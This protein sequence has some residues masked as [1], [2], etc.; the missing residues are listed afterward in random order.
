MKK[1]LFYLEPAIFR[2]DPLFLAPHISWLEAIGK[3]LSLTDEDAIAIVSSAPLCELG[4]SKLAEGGFPKIKTKVI[5]VG[6]ALEEFGGCRQAYAQDL[7]SS[8]SLPI[9]NQYLQTRIKSIIRNF[10]PDLVIATAENRYI[11]ALSRNSPRRVGTFFI[12]K[13]P[14]PSWTLK[15]RFYLDPEGHQPNSLLATRWAGI[16]AED[17]EEEDLAAAENFLAEIESFNNRTEN[18]TLQN[19]LKDHLGKNPRETILVSLQPDEWL[20]WEGAIQS[21][22]KPLDVLTNCCSAFPDYNILPTFHRNIVGL[23]DDLLKDMKSMFPN[24]IDLPTHMVTGNTERLIP[25]VDHVYSVSS[26][27]GIT[28]VINSK[29]LISD[30][31]S[32]LHGAAVTS[33]DFLAGKRSKLTYDQKIRLVAWLLQKYSMPFSDLRTYE[34]YESHGKKLM[35]SGHVGDVPAGPAKHLD[36]LP[37][38]ENWLRRFFKNP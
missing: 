27:T 28:A 31:R 35:A 18:I 36:T 24:L 8:P 17:Y 14:L 13:A 30:A 19:K 10:D 29:N 32:F 33:S 12:E 22:L 7:Y 38:R 3:N 1:L 34:D 21:P 23:R 37:H 9:K 25:A 15:G 26:A 5:C 16:I 6:S 2:N 20:S 11:S 4:R